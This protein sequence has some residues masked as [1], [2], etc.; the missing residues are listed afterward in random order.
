MIE[1]NLVP[2]VKRELLKAKVMRN[3]V[4][5]SA[6]TAGAFA[7]GAVVVLGLILGGQLALEAIND[8][9]IKSKTE[10]LRAVE[11]I[12]KLVT[13]QQ[14]LKMINQLSSE[15]QVNSRL[16]DAIAAVNPTAPNSIKLTSLKLNPEERIITIEGS[17]E[18]GY[19]ALETFK[20]MIANTQVKVTAKDQAEV[21]RPLAENVKAGEANFGE[22]ADGKKVLRFSFTFTYPEELLARTNGSV[23]IETP[24][25]QTDVTDSRLGVPDSLF[26]KKKTREKR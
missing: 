23:V 1:V 5:A 22:D 2:D 11:D 20:K 26:E 21:K 12:D 7:A 25:S 13:I 17:A 6:V 3:T 8:G 10:E 9:T 24:T 16:F 15:R 19:T 4:M 18:N 14:Q